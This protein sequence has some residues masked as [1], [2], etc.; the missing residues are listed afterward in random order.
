MIHEGRIGSRAE[1]EYIDAERA[2]R[3]YRSLASTIKE[4]S[5]E[6]DEDDEDQGKCVDGEIDV[7]YAE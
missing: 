6:E 3:S 2:L 4:F 5:F 1:R 7:D